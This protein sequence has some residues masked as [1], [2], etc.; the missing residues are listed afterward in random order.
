MPIC[1]QCGAS[2]PDDQ[3]FCHRCGTP[4]AD[5]TEAAPAQAETPTE[6]APAPSAPESYHLGG[7]AA[8]MPPLPPE[9]PA[10]AP[11]WQPSAQPYAAVPA[12]EG[13]YPPFYTPPKRKVKVLPIV[14]GIVL[15]LAMVAGAVLL[16]LSILSGPSLAGNWTELN[17]GYSFVFTD[18]TIDNGQSVFSYTY[19]DGILT[20]IAPNGMQQNYTVDIQGNVMMWIDQLYG[21]ITVFYRTSEMPAAL[22]SIY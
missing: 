20:T 13:G 6:P 17:Y 15:F 22:R 2:C 3:S 11:T 12:P 10:P 8:P 19:E 4:L 21:E 1:R 14:L 18:D 16:F 9:A 5:P 7:E